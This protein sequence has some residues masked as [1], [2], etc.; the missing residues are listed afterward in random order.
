ML[1]RESFRPGW[2]LCAGCGKRNPFLTAG[3]LAAI[4]MLSSGILVEGDGCV[5]KA[6]PG[7]CGAWNILF[8]D[9]RRLVLQPPPRFAAAMAKVPRP[10]FALVP[11]RAHWSVARAGESGLGIRHPNSILV[12]MIGRHAGNGADAES[13][14]ELV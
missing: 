8:P 1:F 9:S 3:A 11:F 5:A 6:V 14:A 12:P 7:P 4:I 2:T 10:L 13:P